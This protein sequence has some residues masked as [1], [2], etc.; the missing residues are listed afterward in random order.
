MAEPGAKKAL[1]KRPM[2][3]VNVG[4]SPL[5]RTSLEAPATPSL[6]TDPRVLIDVHVREDSFGLSIM[7]T[8]LVE[9]LAKLI[10]DEF[11]VRFPERPRL[12]CCA[13]LDEDGNLLY[14]PHIVGNALEAKI[15][16]VTVIPYDETLRRS[17][18]RFVAN[19]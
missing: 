1:K 14:F 3:S 19:I 15:A 11:N 18:L 8:L 16:N 12:R 7:R 9:E 17:I 5:Q 4:A 10:Q 13:L 6:L 2:M